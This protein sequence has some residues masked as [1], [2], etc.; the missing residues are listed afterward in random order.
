[1]TQDKEQSQYYSLSSEK[2]WEHFSIFLQILTV[3]LRL[4]QKLLS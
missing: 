1:M 3:D 4:N 2:G